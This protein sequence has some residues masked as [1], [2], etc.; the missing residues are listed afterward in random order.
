L[1]IE[2]QIHNFRLTKRHLESG[3][4][5]IVNVSFNFATSSVSIEGDGAELVQVL[6]LVREIAP[7]LPNISIVAQAATGPKPAP[8]GNGQSAGNAEI[9]TGG[10][11]TMRQFVRKLNLTNQSERIAAIAY[12]QSRH[13]AIPTFSPKEMG[14]WFL[15]C[16]MQR[17]QQMPVAVFDAKKK[18]GFLESAGHGS[19]KISTQGENLIVGKL[20]EHIEQQLG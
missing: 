1:T 7:N 10:N 8:V 16:G 20:E 14:E 17:P 9:G 4:N 19:W 5:H 15:Q 11:Q 12:Y 3:G 6:Q 13:A 2:T 18:Y